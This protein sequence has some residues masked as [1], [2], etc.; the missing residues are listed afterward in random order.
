MARRGVHVG[1]FELV[2][3]SYNVSLNVVALADEG[4]A[5]FLHSSPKRDFA[6]VQ[7]L[8]RLL[9]ISRE[10]RQAPAR[11]NVRS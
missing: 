8:G 7:R 2:S 9:A 3:V 5:V 11:I 6:H 4:E 10:P 1:E